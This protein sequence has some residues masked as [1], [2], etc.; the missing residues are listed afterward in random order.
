MN[1][2]YHGL[3][4]IRAYIDDLLISI[5]RDW[6]DHVHKLELTINKLKEK[7]LKYN[8]EKSFLG[9]TEMEYLGFWVT[10]N[11]KKTINKKIEAITNMK[12][13]TY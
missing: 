10:R 7:G 2:L 1:D 11:G 12:Q 5:K 4:F 6:T 3:E 8:I 13:T 9:R